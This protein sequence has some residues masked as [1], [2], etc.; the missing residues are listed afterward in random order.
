ME[1]YSKKGLLI[2]LITFFTMA[3]NLAFAIKCYTKVSSAF[4]L[5]VLI[6]NVIALVLNVALFAVYFVKLRTLSSKE[7]D[8]ENKE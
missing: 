5:A 4:Y 7:R 8:S 1:T 6:V 3:V 2:F